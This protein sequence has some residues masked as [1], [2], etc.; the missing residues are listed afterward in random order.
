MSDEKINK[1]DFLEKQITSMCLKVMDDD[2]SSKSQEDKLN[3]SEEDEQ[4]N[5][6]QKK[7]KFN[8]S[9]PKNNNFYNNNNNNN[10]NPNFQR[11]NRTNLTINFSNQNSFPFSLNQNSIKNNR[12][13]YQTQIIHSPIILNPNIFNNNL[14]FSYNNQTQNFNFQKTYQNFNQKPNFMRN[15]NRKKTYEIKNEKNML[16]KPKNEDKKFGTINYQK[17]INLKLEV[18]L[19]ELKNLLIRT[20]KIDHFIYSKIQGNLISIIKTHKGSRIFQ[21][22]LKNTHSDIIHQIF[23]EINSNLSELMID[24]YANYF[25]KKFFTYLNQKDRVEFLNSIKNS[26]LQLSIDK[27]GTYPLQGIIEHV[28]SKNE[29]TIIIDTLKNHIENLYIDTYGS[30]VLEKIISCF[31]EEYVSFIYDF[32]IE[33][34]L[35]LAFNNNGICVIKKILTFTHKKNLHEKIKNIV[36]Q[37]SLELIQHSFG[38][39]VIQVIVESWEDEEIKEI[40]HLFDKKF[41]MLSLQKYS[42]NVVE[43]CIEKF[44]EILSQYINEVCESNKIYEVMKNN[45][46]NYVIQK[47]L[48]LCEGEDKKKFVLN[49]GKNIYKL[50][51][52]KLIT[53][54][55]KILMPHLQSLKINYQ[56]EQ[57]EKNYNDII[58]NIINDSEN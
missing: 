24:S 33:N 7:N 40:L 46:G 26:L 53:K 51:D 32:I 45:F 12:N 56:K 20:E 15:N 55:K 48:K 8:K 49:I 57:K 9:H 21:N 17:S 39:Y 19:Y 23:L 36:K 18:L 47:A 4:Q 58:E 6:N 25:C 52:K 30:H 37:N 42:S 50:N 38:N 10:N 28:G 1:K 11:M 34:F 44:N 54:W 35:N 3:F 13:F 29:K 43:R 16:E 27:I 2:E 41:T 14:L 22:Y 31:E 5:K